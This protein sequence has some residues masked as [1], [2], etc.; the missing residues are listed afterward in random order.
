MNKE[1]ERVR[2]RMKR[3]RYKE[4]YRKGTLAWNEFVCLT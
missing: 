1:K 3:K 4:W 2:K